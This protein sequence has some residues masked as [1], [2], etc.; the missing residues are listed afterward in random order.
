MS[1]D[2]PEERS[3]D[4]Q[5]DA[6]QAFQKEQMARQQ[7]AIRKQ[8][9]ELQKR[10]SDAAGEKL[11]SE[12]E[13]MAEQM[14]DTI[15]DL[16]GGATDGQLVKRQQNILSRMLNAEKAVQER[17]KSKERKAR[18]PE[19]YERRENPQIT[20][21][22]LRQEIRSRLNDPDQTDFKDDYQKLIEYYFE[23]LEDLNVQEQI[24]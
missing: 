12:M 5:Q 6:G 19:D 22:E 18:R 16:R 21:E 8:L 17:G 10:G 23:L 4:A 24:N 3:G 11:M 15:N 9:K 7:N 14:E 1:N 2:P 20:M 13:R